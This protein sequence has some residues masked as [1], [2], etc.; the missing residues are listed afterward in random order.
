V[1]YIANTIEW[2]TGRLK[3]CVRHS[4]SVHLTQDTMTMSVRSQMFGMS[5]SKISMSE[6]SVKLQRDS[7]T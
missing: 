1:I 7:I 2:L 5:V 4:K 3:N 6:G